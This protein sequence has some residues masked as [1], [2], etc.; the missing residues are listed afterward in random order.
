MTVLETLELAV[1]SLKSKRDAGYN[2]ELSRAKAEHNAELNEF[3]ATK[4]VEL[5][6]AKKKLEAAFDDDVKTK[7]DK[8]NA[9]AESEAEV[10]VYTLDQTI[11]N[12]DDNIAKL[13]A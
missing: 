4:E 6:D 10:S 3:I 8:I 7:T 1:T 13:K 12:I 2:E 9:I 11:K 5:A